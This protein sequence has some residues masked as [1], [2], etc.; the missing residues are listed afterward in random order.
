[1]KYPE[2][3]L[4]PSA[5]AEESVALG[6]RLARLRKAR[7]LRQADAASRAGLSRSTAVLIERGDPGRTLAQVLR[8]LEAIAPGLSLLGLLTDTDPALKALAQTEATQRVRPLSP[9]QLAA[10]DF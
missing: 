5:R 9:Q 7:R 1:M 6:V 4:L 2:A 3:P 10:L 8:Y